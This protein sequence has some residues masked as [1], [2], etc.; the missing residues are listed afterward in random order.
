[1]STDNQVAR[2]DLATGKL[3]QGSLL[4]VDDS[5]AVSGITG[6]T[7][8]GNISVTGTVDG[9]DVSTDGATLDGHTTQIAARVSGP[10]SS[11]DQAIVRFDGTGGKTAQ[12]SVVTVTDAGAMAG[13]TGL[14][15]TALT[16]NGNITVTG[17]VDGVDVSALNTTVGGK[18]DALFTTNPQTGTTYSAVLADAGRLITMTN[19]SSNTVTI[20]GGTFAQGTVITVVQ[21]GAGATTV[22]V[23]TNTLRNP[24]PTNRIRAQ[25]GTVT[26]TKVDANNWIASGDFAQS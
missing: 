14:T 10:A 17:N 4:V 11:T 21:M 15:T 22:A 7:M 8:T 2:F 16:V 6:I 3:I 24:N 12:N 20:P 9:R 5:G 19:A 1:M 13:L 26:L 25:Y 23:T 18:A